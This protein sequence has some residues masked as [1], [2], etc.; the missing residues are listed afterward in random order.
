MSIFITVAHPF[1]PMNYLLILPFRLFEPKRLNV[2]IAIVSN[3]W[4][5]SID[6]TR[7]VFWRSRVE[8]L[9]QYRFF[10]NILGKKSCIGTLFNFIDSFALWSSSEN[11]SF[12]RLLFSVVVD[13]IWTIF[14]LGSFGIFWPQNLRRQIL[15]AGMDL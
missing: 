10:K 5:D 15:S 14:G 2:V 7:E 1:E 4:D 11:M 13:L 9:F 12:G 3:A 6:E 8:V